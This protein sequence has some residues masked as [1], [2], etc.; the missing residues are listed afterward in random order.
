M[1]E[2]KDDIN[3]WTDIPCSW[4]GRINIVKM[5][6]LPNAIHRF[7]VIPIKLPMAFFTELEQKKFH[8][9]YEN[10]KYPEQPKPSGERRIEL[11]ESTFLTSDYTTKLQSSRQYG[12]GTKTEIQTN[13]TRSKAQR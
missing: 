13:G 8:T 6:I 12:T 7:S 1:K 11:E 10:T 2:I 9:L 3:R 4:V 5:L